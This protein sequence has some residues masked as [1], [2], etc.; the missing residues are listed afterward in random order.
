MALRGRRSGCVRYGRPAPA[1][2]WPRDSFPSSPPRSSWGPSRPSLLKRG[3]RTSAPASHRVSPSGSGSSR[4]PTAPSASRSSRGRT[5]RRRR[6]SAGS[7][8]PATCGPSRSGPIRARSPSP[9]PSASGRSRW[10]WP[11]CLLTTTEP[12]ESSRGTRR[13]GP[14]RSR[15]GSPTSRPGRARR[16]WPSRRTGASGLAWGTCRTMPAA[17]SWRWTRGGSRRGGLTGPALKRGR[18]R[19]AATGRPTWPGR[20]WRGATC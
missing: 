15:S 20:G 2:R 12:Y 6:S 4:S 5:A 17:P 16:A 18:S 1:P 10:P 9:R 7:A 11:T 19:W 14:R 3:E 13:R 8:R